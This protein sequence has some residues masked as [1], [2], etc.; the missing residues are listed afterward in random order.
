MQGSQEQAGYETDAVDNLVEIRQGNNK[1]SPD[2]Q[3]FKSN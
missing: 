3:W 1:L 2:S